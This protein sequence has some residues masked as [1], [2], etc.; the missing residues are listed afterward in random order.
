M[1]N[2]VAFLIRVAC[3]AFAYLMHLGY[4]REFAASWEAIPRFYADEVVG[5]A[6]LRSGK[7]THYFPVADG[8]SAEDCRLQAMGVLDAVRDR[9]HKAPTRAR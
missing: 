4:K 2:A 7:M 8:W 1:L 5:W 3:G 9:T 6:V